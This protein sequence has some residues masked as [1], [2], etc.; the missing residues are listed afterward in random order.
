MIKDVEK[1][2]E[3]LK[4]PITELINLSLSYFTVTLKAIIFS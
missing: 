1:Q 3:Q 4:S 2:L